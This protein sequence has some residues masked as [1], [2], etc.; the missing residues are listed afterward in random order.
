MSNSVK[1]YLV[2]RD[3]TLEEC[4]WLE[5]PVRAGSIVYECS[6]SD[7]GARPPW[8][9]ACTNSPEGDYPFFELPLD[10]LREVCTVPPP[11]WRCTREGGH[12]GPCAA[13]PV[14]TPVPS[15]N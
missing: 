6:G 3:V 1:Q 7:Y 5:A 12:E 10:A 14:W 4:F 13:R 9:Q 8:D 15:I 2:I 11:G